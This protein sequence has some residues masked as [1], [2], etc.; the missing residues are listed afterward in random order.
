MIFPENIPYLVTVNK[1]IT[2][3]R[4]ERLGKGNIAFLYTNSITESIRIINQDDNFVSG[5]KYYYYYHP[6]RVESERNGKKKITIYNKTLPDIIKTVTSQ[7]KLIPY[8]KKYIMHGEVPRNMYFELTPYLAGFFS[9]NGRLM[10]S[11]KE[12]TYWEFMKRVINGDYGDY[13]NRFV[14]INADMYP[15]TKGNLISKLNNPLFMIYYTLFKDYE[16]AQ[17]VDIDFY[18]Y[19]GKRCMKLNLSKCD[20][21]SFRIYKR[22]LGKIYSESKKHNKL[23]EAMDEESISRDNVI[24]EVKS[25]VNI[26]SQDYNFVGKDTES[27]ES[28]KSTTEVKKKPLASIPVKTIVD[29]T[30]KINEITDKSKKYDD[31]PISDAELDAKVNEKINKVMKSDKVAD[32]KANVNELSAKTKEE[33]E[34]DKELMNEIYTKVQ[35]EKKPAVSRSSLRDAKLL[36]EQKNITCKN[37]KLKDIEDIKVSDVKIETK[38]IS[39]ALKTPNNDMKTV[40]FDNLDRV[41]N[42]NVME[43]DIVNAF[44]SLNTKSIPMYI[45]K[46]DVEDTSDELNYKETYTV[47][48]EDANRQRHTLKV[49]IPKFIDDKFMLIGGNKKLIKNQSFY[50][51]VTKIGPDEVQIVTNY[52]KMTIRRV[53]TK[54]LGSIERLN[55][56]TKDSEELQSAITYG[57]PFVDNGDVIT[58]IE[59]DELSKYIQRFHSKDTTIYFSQKDAKEVIDNIIS[60]Y[61]DKNVFT[62]IPENSLFIGMEKNEPIFI[63]IDSQ[64]DKNG[65][66]IIDIMLESVSKDIQDAYSHLS[67]PKRL[68]YANVV[69]MKHAIP[70]MILIGFWEGISTIFKKIGLEYTIQNSKPKNMKSNEVSIRFKDCY[71]VYKENVATSLLMNGLRM[72]NT[73]DYA[74]TDFDTRE[75]YTD[76]FKKVYG[77]GSVVNALMNFYDFTVDPIT[78]EVLK[79]CNMPTE[80]VDIVIYAT[81]LLADNQYRL[82]IDQRLARIRRN[83]IV[84]AILYKSIADQYVNFKNSNGRK[85]LSIQRDIVLKTLMEQKTVEDYSVLNP[86]LEMEEVHSVSSKGFRGVNLD[87]AYTVPR[88]SYDKSMIGIIAPNAA[89]DGNVGVTKTLSLEPKINSVRGYVD[90]TNTEMDQLEDVNLLSGGELCIP[91]AAA[92][93]DPTRLGHAIKQSRHVIPTKNSSPVLISNGY[94]EAC[95]FHLSSEFVVNADDDGK[96]I[97]YDDD[98]KIMVVQYASG[99]YKA[100]DLGHHIVKNGGGG[101]YLSNQLITDLKPGDSFKKDDVLAWHKDYFTKDKINGCRMNMGTLSKVAIMSTYNTYEDGTFTTEKLSADASTEM[102]F[103]KSVAIGKN[104]NIEYIVKVGDTVNVGDSLIQFDTSY[105][106]SELNKLLSSLGENDDIKDELLENSRNNV[107]SKYAG[108]IEDIAIYAT[109]PLDEMSESLRKIV[110]KYYAHINKK[111]KLLE[112]YDPESKSSIVKCG[113]L[114]NEP[115]KK[116]DPNKYG[117]IRGLKVEDGV[118]IWFYIKHSEPLE[119][120]SK[121]AN[122]TALKNVNGEVLKKGYEPYSDM[123]PEEE[124][125]TIIASNSILKRMVPSILISAL[126]NKCIVELKRKLKDIYYD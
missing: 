105:D 74:L 35:K 42:E 50:L 90:D 64:V 69:V 9:L 39:K 57:N 63:D 51:P 125:S 95:R 88:R 101:F 85:K 49:D 98:T 38:D 56:L 122:F 79:D 40:R 36:Q 67:P 55:K 123:H 77:R 81:K 44:T 13:E 43:K 93:D 48:L 119:V 33:I 14:I 114:V 62:N 126:G 30:K 102:V 18:I 84:P 8:P 24:E 70:V 99:K 117:A 92:I 106:D 121:L 65:R 23:V 76:Y 66:S 15:D 103:A 110:E 28:T 16:L 68:M 52:N 72:F 87:E 83:E 10:P 54:S 91:L 71:L 73:M 53:D 61:P 37:I 5:G 1:Q 21:D 116:I 118:A 80:I 29:E 45:R 89:P 112:S 26:F 22:E 109:V 96:V 2:L 60:N 6:F 3:P 107:K 86:V 75:P 11:M 59:Y 104:S 31:K 12:K 20:E 47:S 124:I 19:S 58:T 120:G 25:K 108:V 78:L 17:T 7:T 46:I 94:E 113:V 41:Y 97:K 32:T 100:I 115:T 27:S 111:K 4:G 82:D 34:K